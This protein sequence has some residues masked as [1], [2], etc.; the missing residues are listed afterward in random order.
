MT[1][2]CH[3]CELPLPFLDLVTKEAGSTEEGREQESAGGGGA[4]MRRDKG[5]RCGMRRGGRQG[6]SGSQHVPPRKEM[7]DQRDEMQAAQ[8]K[9]WHA[10]SAET[11]LHII[12]SVPSR[13]CQSP[14]AVWQVAIGNNLGLCFLNP[15]GT[16]RKPRKRRGLSCLLSSAPVFVCSIS[17]CL[18]PASVLPLSTVPSVTPPA[19]PIRTAL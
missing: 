5:S 19:D 1:F 3:F 2:H 18:Y 15:C 17:S 7:P 8:P 6:G 12:S 4:R 13:P 16:T 10:G 11:G 9:R 14:A